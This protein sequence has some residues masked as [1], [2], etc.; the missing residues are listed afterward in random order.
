MPPVLDTKRNLAFPMN[1]LKGF[2]LF[3]P[4]KRRAQDRVALQQSI[5]SMPVSVQDRGLQFL[6]RLVYIH[7]HPRALQGVI[8]HALLERG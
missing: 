7:A 3:L 2:V 8:Q 4:M 6:D 1:A 5:P